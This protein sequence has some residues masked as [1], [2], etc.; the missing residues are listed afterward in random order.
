MEKIKS[1]G[2]ADILTTTYVIAEKELMTSYDKSLEKLREIRKINRPADLY[3]NYHKA[4]ETLY[5]SFKKSYSEYSKAAKE[6][7]REEWYALI[8]SDHFH[9]HFTSEQG[10]RFFTSDKEAENHQLPYRIIEE[11]VSS[12][13]FRAYE[14]ASG[15]ED[16]ASITDS[17]LA[18]CTQLLRY[19]P[20]F[21]KRRP[22]YFI[23][24]HSS[25]LGVMFQKYGTLTILIGGTSEIE[26]SYAHKQ[27]IGTVRISGTAKLT[28]N[29]QNSKLIRKLLRLQGMPE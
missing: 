28:K 14:A 23:D 26:Y 27:S 8:C 7:R 17:L 16:V 12:F 21:E 22:H 24:P 13:I 2:Q 5:D 29:L 18:A 3:I 10:V 15:E 9:P 4:S 19:L 1:F 6:V 25:K 11:L 20:E